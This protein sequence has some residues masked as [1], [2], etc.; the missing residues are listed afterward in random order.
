M[1]AVKTGWCVA[2]DMDVTKTAAGPGGSVGSNK[3]K[4][5]DWAAMR[6]ERRTTCC[7]SRVNLTINQQNVA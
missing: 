3:A 4:G 5:L 6:E 7:L 1:E 2:V